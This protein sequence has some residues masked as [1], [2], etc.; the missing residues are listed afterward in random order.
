VCVYI[1]IVPWRNFWNVLKENQHTN[2]P[3]HNH[4]SHIYNISITLDEIL[5]TKMKKMTIFTHL[6]KFQL[7]EKVSLSTFYSCSRAIFAFWWARIKGF[8]QVEQFKSMRSE[9][10]WQET[11]TNHTLNSYTNSPTDK[12]T[13]TLTLVNTNLYT[14]THT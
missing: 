9:R 3:H 7:R 2:R 14:P 4:P 10:K 1:H 11:N 5:E 6:R 12:H 8:Y 13:H